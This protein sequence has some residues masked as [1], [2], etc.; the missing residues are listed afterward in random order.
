MLSLTPSHD[1][2]V[3]RCSVVDGAEDIEVAWKDDDGG[4][5]ANKQAAE[6]LDLDVVCEV[7]RGGEALL[8][9]NIVACDGCDTAVHQSCY[10]IEEVPEGD[11]FC[12]R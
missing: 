10:G 7:C 5:E 2:D 6:D 9:D 11:W 8:D 1:G 3:P 12:A 4:G